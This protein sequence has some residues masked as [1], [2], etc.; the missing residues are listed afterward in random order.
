MK[1][2]R[3]WFKYFANYDNSAKEVFRDVEFSE[4]AQTMGGYECKD[5]YDSKEAFFDAYLPHRRMRVYDDY[6]TRRLNPEEKGLS[7]GSGRGTNELYLIEKGYNIICSDLEQA[8]A[9]ETKKLFPKSMFVQYNVIDGPF[10]QKF[11]Y[12]LCLSSLFLFDKKDLV[13]IFTNMY[14]SLQPNGKLMFDPGGCE[15]GI[16]SYCIDDS[17]PKT[18]L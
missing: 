4:H 8:C 16:L 11:D 5:G 7:I 18:M 13:K 10:A 6:L 14:E 2:M 3:K 9:E 17:T 1:K 15:Q 12:I